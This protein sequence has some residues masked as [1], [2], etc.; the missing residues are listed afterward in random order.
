MLKK[1]YSCNLCGTAYEERKLCHQELIGLNFSGMR[2]FKLDS[3]YSTDGYHICIWCAG[4]IVMQAPP[5]LEGKVVMDKPTQ[6]QGDKPINA[7]KGEAS[8]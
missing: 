6:P 3:P 5:L 2:N 8:E 4:Q 7:T 1:I